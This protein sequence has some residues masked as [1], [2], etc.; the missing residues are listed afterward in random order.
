MHPHRPPQTT[1]T[2]RVSCGSGRPVVAERINRALVIALGAHLALAIGLAAWRLPWPATK[3][4]AP[5]AI[6]VPMGLLPTARQF[7]GDPAGAAGAADAPIGSPSWPA[8]PASPTVI[9]IPATEFTRLPVDAWLRANPCPTNLVGAGFNDKAG[10]GLPGEGISQDTGGTAA[11][12]GVGYVRLPQPKYPEV[13]RQQ[14]WEGTALLRV[15]VGE[16]GTVTT[17]HV[18]QSSGHRVLD[19]AAVQAVRSAKFVA[20]ASPAWVEIPISFRLS[21]S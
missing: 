12:R 6:R 3:P 5:S 19:D 4:A 16:R 13:A 17:V 7:T 11:G 21:R 14:G 2:P 20:P 8:L 15:E 10:I 18:I 9:A 1:L